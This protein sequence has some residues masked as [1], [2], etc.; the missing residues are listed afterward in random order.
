MFI[1]GYPKT[2]RPLNAP[3]SVD[4]CFANQAG[5]ARTAWGRRFVLNPAMG[6][7]E[8]LQLAEE[9]VTHG[10][11]DLEPEEGAAGCAVGP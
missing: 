10:A 2:H 11:D 7:T 6:Q 8:V 4:C 1:E 5:A 9:S 3:A